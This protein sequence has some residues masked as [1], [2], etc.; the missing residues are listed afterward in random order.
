MSSAVAYVD[1]IWNEK[2]APLYNLKIFLMGGHWNAV[3]LTLA[4]IQTLYYF[5]A[6]H[7]SCVLTLGPGL[8]LRHV[9][10]AYYN[11]MRL[12][13]EIFVAYMDEICNGNFAMEM[14]Q[15]WED[16]E[17][18]VCLTLACI[19]TLY[20]FEVA[21]QSCVLTLGPGIRLQPVG[22]YVAY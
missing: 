9:Y 12:L 13:V 18:A 17:N 6:A 16:M 22:L 8:R 20:Y 3:C 7:Q 14:N 15:T 21:H 4:C 2:C 19:Q 11:A 5:V 10:V 1:E